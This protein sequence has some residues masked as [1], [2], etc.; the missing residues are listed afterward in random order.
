MADKAKPPRKGRRASPDEL[1]R[2]GKTDKTREIELSEEN[3]KPVG[4]GFKISLD[5][6]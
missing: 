3:L 1:L 2:R 4:G 5:K 6:I